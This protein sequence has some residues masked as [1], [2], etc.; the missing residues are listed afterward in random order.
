MQGKLL[1][2][3]LETPRR[4]P[5]PHTRGSKTLSCLGKVQSPHAGWVSGFLRLT[6]HSWVRAAWNPL[7]QLSS[8]PRSLLLVNRR[9][10]LT[11]MVEATMCDRAHVDAKRAGKDPAFPRS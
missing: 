3:R 4:V 2:L 9:S 10:N 6:T 8:I 11:S 5:T 7:G 1:S